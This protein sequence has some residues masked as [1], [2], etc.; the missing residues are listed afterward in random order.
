MADGTITGFAKCD[1][2]GGCTGQGL[3][4]ACPRGGYLLS[5]EYRNKNP[6][7]PAGGGTGG[8]CVVDSGEGKLAIGPDRAGI[9]F[10]DGPYAG[11]TSK[12]IVNGNAQGHFCD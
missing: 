4:E 8:A 1:Q 12:G 11:Y 7:V 9:G 10:L 5:F 2:E 3:P 6:F